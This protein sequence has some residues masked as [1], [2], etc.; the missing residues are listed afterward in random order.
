[1][2]SE[3]A[4]A[5]AELTDAFLVNPHDIDSLKSTVLRAVH[6]DPEELRR[7]MDAMRR[8]LREHDIQAWGHRYLTDLLAATRPA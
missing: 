5:A 3:F 7:R 8:Y 6:A 1:V 2:L 4:G